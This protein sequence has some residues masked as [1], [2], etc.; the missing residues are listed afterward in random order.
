MCIQ[1]NRKKDVLTYTDI[2]KQTER[3]TDGAKYRK[4]RRE[5]DRCADRQYKR[6]TDRA[7]RQKANRPTDRRTA[8]IRV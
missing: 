7:D 8:S 2:H 6:Q 4:A 3:Q 5:T 1:T